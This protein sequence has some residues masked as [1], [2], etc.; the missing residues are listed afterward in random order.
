MKRF[1]ESDHTKPVTGGIR[2]QYAG[3][4]CLRSFDETFQCFERYHAGLKDHQQAGLRRQ[5]FTQQAHA[6][7]RH[8]MNKS[9]K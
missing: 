2:N 1:G 9:G 6:P 5:E 8:K 7:I 4:R 3:L